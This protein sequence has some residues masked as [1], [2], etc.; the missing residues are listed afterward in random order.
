M[1]WYLTDL[2]EFELIQNS[3]CRLRQQEK[4]FPPTNGRLNL[5]SYFK[6][7]SIADGVWI[8]MSWPKFC[9][10]F[11]SG[12]D[13]EI[14]YLSAKII[15]MRF[16]MSFYQYPQFIVPIFFYK[17]LVII[18]NF[19]FRICLFLRLQKIKAVAMRNLPEC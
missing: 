12:H 17:L 1:S 13:M 8:K 4:I 19:L 3:F 11:C 7:E 6:G 2:F 5:Q 10:R 16:F 15:R 9:R 18:V 14:F